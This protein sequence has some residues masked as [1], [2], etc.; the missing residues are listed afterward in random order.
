MRMVNIHEAKTLPLLTADSIV[1]QYRGP[2]RKGK[3]MYG[4]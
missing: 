2:V 4:V 1:A 3:L